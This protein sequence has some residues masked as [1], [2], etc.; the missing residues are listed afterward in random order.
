MFAHQSSP[1]FCCRRP[2]TSCLPAKGDSIASDSLAMYP[3]AP[4]CLQSLDFIRSTGRQAFETSALLARCMGCRT[5]SSVL[6]PR[7]RTGGFGLLR[8]LAGRRLAHLPWVAACGFVG[9]W[10]LDTIPK[11]RWGGFE[12]L[13]C[14]HPFALG[15][16]P[17]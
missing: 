9:A 3:L 17:V 6:G 4:P 14:C 16:P 2:T 7:D 11:E 12:V 10:N 13:R 5:W 1:E 15:H 8:R